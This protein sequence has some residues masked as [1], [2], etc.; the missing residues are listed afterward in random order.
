MEDLNELASLGEELLES[1]SIG[2]VVEG[3]FILVDFVD[4]V[5]LGTGVGLGDVV[6]RARGR[7]GEEGE[8]STSISRDERGGQAD[9]REIELS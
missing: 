9:L 1:G 8:R 6:L 4:D 7:G 2:V 3:S 5:S